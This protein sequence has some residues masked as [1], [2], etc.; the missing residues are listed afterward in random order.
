[1]YEVLAVAF[2]VTGV[3]DPEDWPPFF[4]QAY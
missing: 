3:D 4:W 1:L 2:V